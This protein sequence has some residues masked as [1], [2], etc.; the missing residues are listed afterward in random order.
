MW[1]KRGDPVL[2][3]DLRKWAD[4]FLITPLSSNT[5]AKLALGLSDNLLVGKLFLQLF[6]FCF[7]QIL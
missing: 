7:L 5:L 4:I 1:G 3:I 6:L 2:H